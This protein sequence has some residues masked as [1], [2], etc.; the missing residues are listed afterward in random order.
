MRVGVV[1]E[2]VVINLRKSERALGGHRTAGTARHGWHR[3]RNDIARISLHRSEYDNRDIH[4]S[5]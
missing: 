4:P 1:E 3:I 2:R 5:M